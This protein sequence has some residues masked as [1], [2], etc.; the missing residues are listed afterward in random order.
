MKHC[1]EK[2][3]PPKHFV[4]FNF[5]KFLR[6]KCLFL[7]RHNVLVAF[8]VAL[9]L[10]PNALLTNVTGNHVIKLQKSSELAMSDTG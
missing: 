10:F 8:C 6:L 3:H 9:G 4:S 2:T 7:L 5:F 1:F